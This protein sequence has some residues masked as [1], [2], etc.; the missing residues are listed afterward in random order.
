MTDKILPKIMGASAAANYL[1]MAR[2]TFYTLASTD[3]TFPRAVT[4]TSSE[5]RWSRDQIDAWLERKFAPPKSGRA[6]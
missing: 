3:P 1:G 4:L 2:S 5:K 6:A